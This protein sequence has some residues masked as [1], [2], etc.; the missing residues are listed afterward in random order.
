[1][2]R[3]MTEAFVIM[4]RVHEQLVLIQAASDLPLT[5]EERDRI[6]QFIDELSPEDGWSNLIVK[7]SLPSRYEQSEFE[8]R[9]GHWNSFPQLSLRHHVA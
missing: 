7:P 9:L 8:K 6:N 2:L 1:M 3:D 5:G 4:L